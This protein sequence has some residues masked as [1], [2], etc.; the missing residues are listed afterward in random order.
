MSTR[1]HSVS[2]LL[3]LI[4]FAAQ[5]RAQSPNAAPPPPAAKHDSSKEAVI[6]ER[7]LAKLS[8]EADGSGT[9]EM[10][11]DVRIQSQAGVQALAVLSFPYLSANETVEFDYVRVRKPDGSVI[12]TPEYNIQDMPAEVTRTAPMYSDIHEKHVT[13][14]G[15]AVGDVLEYVVRY[16]TVK[17]QVPGEFWF[18]YTFPKDGVVKGEQL[19]ISVPIDKYIKAASPEVTPQIKD[20]GGRRIYSWK[21]SNLQRKDPADQPFRP[22]PPKPSVQLT[23]FKS[24]EDVGRWYGDLQRPQAAVTPAIQAKANELTK[25]LATDDEK[26]R[27]IYDFVAVRYHY[28]SLSF[29][30]GRYQP[31]P[32]QEVLENE[33]GDCKDK[34]TLLAALLKAAGYDAWPALINASGKIDVD[35]PSPGQLNHL[36]T[37]VPVG[38]KTVWLDTTPEVAPFGMLL[39][40]LRDKKALVIPTD[41]AASQGKFAILMDTPAQPPFLSHQTFTAKGTHA[42]GTLTAN[43]HQDITGDQE[44]FYPIVFRNTPAS[45]WQEAGQRISGL[46]GFG[47]QVSEVTPSAVDEIEKPFQLDYVY[48]KK[49]YGDWNTHQIP[50]PVPW[51]GIES[52]ALE[53]KKPEQPVFIGAVGELVYQASI[54]LPPLLAPRFTDKKDLVEDFAEYHATYSIAGGLLS[55]TRKLTLKKSEL[56]VSSWNAYK[57]FCKTLADERD[58]FIDLSAESG[59]SAAAKPNDAEADRWFQDGNE[60]VERG[61]YSKAEE[62]YRRVIGLDP[63]YPNAYGNLGVAELKHNKLEPGLAEIL[64]EEQLNPSEPFWYNTLAFYYMHM[65]KIEQAIEQLRALL[66]IEPDNLGGAMQLASLLGASKKYSDAISMLQKAIELSPNSSALQGALGYVY[67]KNGE[68][69]KALPLLQ[70]AVAKETDFAI[71]NNVGYALADMNVALD[72]AQ[73]YLERALH[74][75]EAA[76]AKPDAP[77]DQQAKTTTELGHVWD[78]LGWL[79]FRQ[80]KYEQAQR[81]LHAAWLLS[82]DPTTGDHLG[83]LL[84]QQ[85]KKSEAAHV[86]KLAYACLPIRPDEKQAILEHYKRVMGKDADPRVLFITRKADGTYTQT[87]S[88]ELSRMRTIKISTTGTLFGDATFLIVISPE[89]VETVKYVTGDEGLRSLLDHPSNLKLNTDFPDAGPVRITRTGMVACTKAFGCTL[90]FLPIDSAHD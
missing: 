84:E 44:L 39:S 15:L 54:E 80:G 74:E 79:Y 72:Q 42:D 12:A 13:V 52:I 28:V 25:G 73:D 8:F 89:K 65:G 30:I 87:P 40:N 23:T 7:S 48:T 19:E 62:S 26:M 4:L 67:L 82:Q 45:Q 49:T 57:A 24:W 34:H 71:L 85:G 10:T 53:E 27:A 37:V 31:H 36:I 17:P 55:V 47:G 76:S 69:A 61:D 35:V 11:V 68:T 63:K 29:G 41:K 60:A 2:A 46:S 66:Q 14:K 83:Q 64:K 9:R 78:S 21:A 70:K 32:A 38:T 22:E 3:L 90:V 77:E 50:A 20:E 81:F 59:S 5:I 75:V 1:F 56:P 16:R 18:E 43:V 86:Y 88:E 33:Y 51:F 6:L 58:R